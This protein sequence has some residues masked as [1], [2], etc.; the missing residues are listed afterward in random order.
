M[1][2][3]ALKRPTGV[4][5]VAV[6]FLLAPFGNILISFAGSGIKNWY[7]LDIITPFIQSVPA[8][9]WIWLGLLFVTGLLLL[10]PHKLSWSLALFSLVLVLIIN[11]YR[12]FNVDTNSIDP[13]FLKV[14]SV[15]AIISTLSVLIIAAYF[16]FPYLDR[17]SKWLST[18]YQRLDIRTGVLV[19]GIKAATESVSNAGCRLSF[20]K[21]CEFRKSDIINLKFVELSQIETEAEVIEKLE[22][23]IRIEFR[24][25]S[26]KFKQDLDLWLK[27]HH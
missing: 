18:A 21:P 11:A 5:L 2:N 9:D 13:I 24:N 12:L 4:Y 14:F 22:F 3:S 6:L 15:L 25:S 23:G 1:S 26:S 17:R 20:D 19:N 27:T 8:A 10:R 16:R 7:R